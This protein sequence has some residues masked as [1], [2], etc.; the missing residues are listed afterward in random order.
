MQ[1]KQKPVAALE[2]EQSIQLAASPPDHPRREGSNFT[3]RFK[4]IQTVFVSSS[5]SPSLLIEV[6]T[7]SLRA[8]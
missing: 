1:T 4:P 6:I 7:R 3:F 2:V 5:L 8:N